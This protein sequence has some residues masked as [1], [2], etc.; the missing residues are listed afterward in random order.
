MSRSGVGA[1]TQHHYNTGVITRSYITFPSSIS[2]HIAPTTTSRQG[3]KRWRSDSHGWC[4]NLLSDVWQ[5]VGFLWESFMDFFS[6][7]TTLC[8]VAF[9]SGPMPCNWLDDSFYCRQPFCTSR[10]T[11]RIFQLIR[12]V[13]I[14][15]WGDLFLITKNNVPILAHYHVDKGVRDEGCYT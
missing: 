13:W 5:R 10:M 3:W 14:W 7:S 15:K 1:M 6:F 9:L 12:E 11:R 2:L 8:A 4:T